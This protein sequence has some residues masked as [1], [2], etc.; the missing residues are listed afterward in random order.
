MVKAD[1]DATWVP[2]IGRRAAGELRRLRRIGLIVA[3]VVPVV[4]V[5]A[6]VLLAAGG[7]GNLLG[8]LLVVALTVCIALFIRAQI[9]LAAAM[10]DWFGVKVR[11][12]P[13]MNIKDFDAFCQKQGLRRPD[14]APTI[15][16]SERRASP[17]P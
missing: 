15:E 6:G 12:L 16:E 5:A 3:T 17:L 14:A 2:R 4:A 8:A 1:F 11:G 7:V 13:L 10:S 9:R